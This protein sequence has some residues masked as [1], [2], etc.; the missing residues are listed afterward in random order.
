LGTVQ[1]NGGEADVA[2]IER[3]GDGDGLSVDSAAGEMVFGSVARVAGDD[4]LIERLTHDAHLIR[5]A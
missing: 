3:G 2:E 4:F 5:H 1:I